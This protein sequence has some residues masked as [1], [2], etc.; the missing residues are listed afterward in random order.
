MKKW[1]FWRN[2]L[3][4][5]L[6]CSSFTAAQASPLAPSK[7]P[8]P[9]PKKNV[10]AVAPPKGGETERLKQL[11]QLL[12]ETG[13]YPGTPTGRLD[14]TTQEAIRH[15]QK[16]YKLKITGQYDA[17]L[18]TLLG[19]DV[20]AKPG[21]YQKKLDMEASAYTTEDPGSGNYTKRGNRLRKGLVAVDPRVIP[22]G[23]RLYVEGYG[24]AVADDIGG[25]I[26][27]NKIDLAYESRKNALQFGRRKVIVYILE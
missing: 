11:Q 16:T 19:Q 13:F 18:L 21:R 2:V 9:P 24:Y 1:G 20:R 27:G 25:A 14:E 15:G 23:T 4:L 8:L 26:K 17:G 10:S 3:I 7:P 6:L 12:A 5:I 22:L